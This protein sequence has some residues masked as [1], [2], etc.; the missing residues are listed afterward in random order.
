M[1]TYSLL[2]WVFTSIGIVLIV[3]VLIKA[4]TEPDPFDEQDA[5]KAKERAEKEAAENEGKKDS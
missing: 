5:E 1:G 4:F 2:S 3:Y